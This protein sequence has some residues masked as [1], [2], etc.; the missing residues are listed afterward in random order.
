MLYTHFDLQTARF[1][2]FASIDREEL[3]QADILQLDE[4]VEGGIFH[5]SQLN[6]KGDTTFFASPETFIRSDKERS[7]LEKSRQFFIEHG[8]ELRTESVSSSQADDFLTIY[9]QITLN[10]NRAIDTNAELVLKKNL[11]TQTPV[12]LFGLYQGNQLISGLL[13]SQVKD[14]FRV[15]FGA[16]KKF[17]E[18][19]GGVGGVLEMELLAFC[20][21]HDIHKISHGLST[22][23]AGIIDKAGV[24]EFK[25]RYG[26]TA[27]PL[28]EWKTTF[29]LS[30]KVAQSDLVFVTAQQ[31]TLGHTI[32]KLTDESVGKKYQTCFIKL[33]EEELLATHINRS[34]ALLAL[35]PLPQ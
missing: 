10:R 17:D 30:P 19:R 6:W 27:Y 8:Y 12:W 35:P 18:I 23:P 5:S 15:M 4:Y 24:F 26:F 2:S 7:E 34:R 14:E 33:Y 3:M 9:K 1:A 11:A 13:A 20:Y 25:S 21:Q 29:I 28:G 16:K 22:N 31:N 32:L